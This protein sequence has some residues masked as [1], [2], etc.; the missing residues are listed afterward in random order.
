MR[1][2]FSHKANPGRLGF[3]LLLVVT[4]SCGQQN[5]KN[6]IQESTHHNDG[7][8]E[9]WLSS[10]L[11]PESPKWLLDLPLPSEIK[12]KL[13]KQPGI[14]FGHDKDKDDNA[15]NINIDPTQ[16][17]Q[18]VSGI[19]MAVEGTTIYAM[20]KN[21]LDEDLTEM[22]KAFIDPETGIGFNMFWIGIGL[23]DFPDGRK[24]S[25]HPQEFYTYQDDS[26]KPFQITMDGHYFMATL[27]SKVCRNIQVVNGC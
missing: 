26:D 1:Q 11:L 25:I 22:I 7:E 16:K 12:Y 14:S 17:F 5:A 20:R 19:G 6:E 8:I 13:D 23:S 15:L 3:I 4:I 18:S 24:V 10:E 2:I 27:P 9:V 21:R